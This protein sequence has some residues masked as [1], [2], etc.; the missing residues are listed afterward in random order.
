MDLSIHKACVPNGNRGMWA[1]HRPATI[2]LSHISSTIT[3]NLIHGGLT[4][5]STALLY[6]IAVV[7]ILRKPCFA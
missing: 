1:A 2:T 4:R 5:G 7:I 6:F 3:Q